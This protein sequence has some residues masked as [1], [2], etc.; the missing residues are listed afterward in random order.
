LLGA[1]LEGTN[2]PQ[3]ALAHYRQ[4]V[5]LKADYVEACFN[6]GHILLATGTPQ[7]AIPQLQQVVRLS[8]NDIEAAVNLALAYAAVN[9]SDDAIAAAER[10]G[11]LAQSTGQVAHAGRIQSWLASYRAKVG[12]Q[13]LTS[14]DTSVP[15]R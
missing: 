9:K 6:L 5:Q 8:A 15:R 7:E 14:R 1:A 11:E 12:G 2:H 13:S 3:Q 4:A 10:A